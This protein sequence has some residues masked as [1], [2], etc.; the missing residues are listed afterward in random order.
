MNAP[1]RVILFL[2]LPLVF[3]VGCQS[4]TETDTSQG[5][6]YGDQPIEPL[7]P[8]YRLAVHPLHNPSKLS[9]AYQPLIDYLNQ[10]ITDVHFELEASRDYQV[11]EAKFRA[12]D[13]E[14]LLPNP[15]QTLEAIK[16]GYHVIAMAGN[17]EDFKGLFIV[18]KDGGIKTP[19][20]LKGKVV[21]YPSRTALAACIMPQYY[22]H[23]HGIDVNRDIEN[24]YVG[25]QESSIM[26]AYLGQSA[27][28]ATWPPPWR[29]FQRDH[30][31]EA[32]ELTVAWETPSLLN[33]S[34]MAR[35]DVP[36]SIRDSVRA[37]IL[38]LDT[39]PEGQAILAGMETARFNAADDAS[40]DAVRNYVAE[41]EKSV[42][43][44]EQK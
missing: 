11:Y 1:L 13:S 7:K 2:L 33:N 40:Y 39:T 37:L 36:A 26:N 25:S 4:E 43:P 20:D 5:P 24:R 17:A 34:V 28:G 32:A 29:L 19:A 10:Q 6:Q 3:F 31:N 18:R 30:P 9:E 42:R 23:L 12:R 35:D 38:A 14:F 41:F 44:V 16:L 27:A 8:L 22:L 21:S 15:W